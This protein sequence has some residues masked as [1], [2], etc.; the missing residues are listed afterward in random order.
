MGLLSPPGHSQDS[1]RKIQ[2][3]GQI[4]NEETED[5]GVIRERARVSESMHDIDQVLLIHNVSKTYREKTWY[6]GTKRQNHAVKNVTLGVSR[7]EILSLLG[8]NGAGK[9]SLLSILNGF[10][11]PSS[12][13]VFI[14]NQD[15]FHSPY[16][17]ALRDIGVCPQ[18]DRLYDKLSVRDHVRIFNGLR[19][20]L[21]DKSEED[22][23]ISDFHLQ[24]HAGKAAD[25]LS[26]G[27]KRKLSVALSF[28]GRPKLILL[29]E[30][31]TGMDGMVKRVMWNKIAERSR[32]SAIILTT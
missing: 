31:S 29:D 14:E 30:P 28:I 21:F 2:D 18:N 27:N 7:G 19:G 12:G 9:S 15:L 8:P 5:E 11:G 13:Q 23:I 16:G 32:E 1:Y 22:R 3:D 20:I 10:I 25:T 24:E 26:G 6:G 17:G 4:V